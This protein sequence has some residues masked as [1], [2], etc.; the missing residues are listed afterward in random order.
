MSTFVTILLIILILLLFTVLYII[1]NRYDKDVKICSS[2]NVFQFNPKFDN[3]KSTEPII[4][5]FIEIINANQYNIVRDFE[6]ANL[7]FFSDFSYIDQKI[8]SIPFKKACEGRYYIY[9][10]CGSDEMASKSSLTVYL[11]SKGYAHMLPRT[12]VLNNAADL[13]QLKNDHTND[14]SIYMVKKNIQRQE[15]NLITSDID[16][17]LNTSP[18]DDYVVCQELLQNPYLVNGRKINIRIY[19]LVISYKGE[20]RFYMYNNGFMYYTPEMFQKNSMERNVNITTGYIDR[21]VYEENPLTF[22]DFFTFL[23]SEKGS[24]LLENI[25]QALGRV[26][27]TYENV[28]TNLNQG[29]PGVKFNIYGVDIAPDE[30]LEVKIMEINK[31]PDLSYKD[32]R[33]KEVKLN[34]VFDMFAMVGLKNSDR[35]KNKNFL[36][37]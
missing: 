20:T 33:D 5:P 16:Y 22:Q 35:E 13:R 32:V 18:K 31:G 7:I 17:I 1:K 27:E 12:Y 6:D 2:I 34:M 21:K 4:S 29:L 9:A 15:G 19:M 26:R 36:R 10:I 11:K 3:F 24:K 14:G 25:Q 37:L 8:K 28:L 30:N 23:G